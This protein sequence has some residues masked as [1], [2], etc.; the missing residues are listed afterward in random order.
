MFPVT[1]VDP[2]LDA[3]DESYVPINEKDRFQYE[4]YSPEKYVDA[5]VSLQVVTRRFEDEKCLAVLEAI[6]KS[7]GRD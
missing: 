3:K 1:T 7:M 2:K 4:L 6:E 5:P